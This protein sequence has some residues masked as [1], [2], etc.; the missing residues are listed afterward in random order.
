MRKLCQPA[1]GMFAFM[2]MQAATISSLKANDEDI[3]SSYPG[4]AEAERP[5]KRSAECG[6]LRASLK[7]LPDLDRRIDLW[8]AG[9]LSAI[10]TDGALWYV[11]LCLSPDIKV[12]YMKVGDRVLAKGAMMRPD[13]DHILLDPCP[14]N[15]QQ[16]EDN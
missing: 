6:E 8:V 9:N 11:S 16:Q 3:S 14:A 2:L 1:A 15:F 10:Q 4:L 12:L 5:A 13:G 7:N